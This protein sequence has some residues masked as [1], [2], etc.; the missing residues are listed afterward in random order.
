MLPGPVGRRRC[1]ARRSRNGSSEFAGRNP[2]PGVSGSGNSKAA[3]GCPAHV[4]AS[5]CGSLD[6]DDPDLID[7]AVGHHRIAVAVDVHV[8][9]DIAAAAALPSPGF[10]GTK[11]PTRRLEPSFACQEQIMRIARMGLAA[12]SVAM[13]LGGLLLGIGAVA[14]A[15]PV[16][17][18]RR[19]SAISTS[20]AIS[21]SSRRVS[22]SPDLPIS[23]WSRTP[24][25]GYNEEMRTRGFRNGE[26]A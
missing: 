18:S 10:R 1:A 4:P 20:P 24:P 19:C 16:K 11:T 15:D 3:L 12:A 6:L 21:A 9:H 8:A 7:H 13:L 17:I 5:V 22:T 14:A 23:A 25:S 2:S 26:N